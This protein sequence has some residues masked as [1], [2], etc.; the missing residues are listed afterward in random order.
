M[1][2][3]NWKISVLAMSALA[4]APIGAITL[5]ADPCDY[6]DKGRWNNVQTGYWHE[7]VS[8]WVCKK[9]KADVDAHFP[10]ENDTVFLGGPYQAKCA[11]VLEEGR[12][13][14]TL[15]GL[16]IAY[17]NGGQQYTLFMRPGSMISTMGNINANY[18]SLRLGGNY[19]TCGVLD[20][21]GGVV[22]CS[23]F[24]IGMCAATDTQKP[25]RGYCYVHG[26][27]TITNKSFMQIGSRAKG[28]PGTLELDNA[29]YDGHGSYTIEVGRDTPWADEKSF[30]ILRGGSYMNA[31]AIA[32]KGTGNA[33]LTENSAIVVKPLNWSASSP[34]AS[35][36]GNANTTNGFYMT[37]SAFVVYKPSYD[38]TDYGNRWA[39]W[40]RIDM[41]SLGCS[42][43]IQKDSVVTNVGVWFWP[44][45][46]AGDTYPVKPP[47][48]VVDGGELYVHNLH[49]SEEVTRG[50]E[51]NGLSAM[52]FAAST[53]AP[54]SGT[55]EFVNAPKVS[56]P[57]VNTN[58]LTGGNITTCTFGIT[59][60]R[61][62]FRFV[63]T[64]LGHRAASIRLQ[65]SVM[66]MYSFVPQGGLQ[67]VQTNRFALLR[68][69]NIAN[70]VM[71]TCNEPQFRAPNQDLWTTGG[72]ADA[73]REW[74]V[75]LAQGAEIEGGQD[76]GAG[77]SSGY[78]RLPR[79]NPETVKSAVV[80]LVMSPGAKTL[81]EIVA[82]LEAAGYPA[83]LNGQDVVAVDLKGSGMMRKGRHNIV[84][85]DFCAVQD[86]VG[87]RDNVKVANALVRSVE[88]DVQRN[89][90]V[91][92]F[93]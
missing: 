8:D 26:G 80:R 52:G 18:E 87:V 14:P 39:H 35:I 27:G 47:R 6:Y 58:I 74:G 41:K 78:V 21:D 63:L 84:L 77:V 13:V 48:Y 40:A 88:V 67:V 11:L 17:G 91:L 69:D 75:A 7:A 73:P 3:I 82:D 64:K 37:N 29:R 51:K 61:P 54:N 46:N 92:I 23:S 62:H 83:T 53:N 36:S 79:F 24:G 15:M 70:A 60:Y 85:F 9:D 5:D 89:G 30:L 32:V 45:A 50:G 90:A 59:P 86:A 38:S 44:A 22:S 68:N 76:L 28:S 66:G 56:F 43:F 34:F 71:T 25:G 19:N 33:V 12:T 1:N 2:R 20:V 10:E 49:M 31:G 42:E 72:F 57:G 16:N 4:T 65:T 55:I 93:K 81:P